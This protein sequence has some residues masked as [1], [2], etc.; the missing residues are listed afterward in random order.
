MKL[1]VTI[2]TE[3]DGQWDYGSPLTTRNVEYWLPFQDLCER[4]GV[5][6]TYLLTSEI[7]EDDRARDLLTEWRRRGSC[8]IGTHLHPWTT[9]PF[10]DRDGFRRNDTVHAF[11]SQLPDDLLREKTAQPHR[12]VLAAFGERPTA[13]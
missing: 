2:D 11:P 6:P 12:A 9:P 1:A 10:A 3:A 4:H 5:V 13:Y 8:E 7:I